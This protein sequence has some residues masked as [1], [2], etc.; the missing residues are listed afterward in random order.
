MSTT[1]AGARISHVSQNLTKL[2]AFK[3]QV[4]MENFKTWSLMRAILLNF[5]LG[6]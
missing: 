3:L 4:K 6:G 1:I 5:D 2:H